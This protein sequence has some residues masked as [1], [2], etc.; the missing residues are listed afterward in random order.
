MGPNIKELFR[1]IEDF[2]EV[3]GLQ[4]KDFLDIYEVTENFGKY[5]PS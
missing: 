2:V 4:M 3:I 1:L 5:W